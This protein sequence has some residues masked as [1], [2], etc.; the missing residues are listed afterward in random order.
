MQEKLQNYIESEAENVDMAKLEEERNNLKN[1][2]KAINTA[3]KVIESGNL[4]AFEK[5]KTPGEPVCKGMDSGE[6]ALYKKELQEMINNLQ[7]ACYNEK[8][9]RLR[10]V[11]KQ[12]KD[13]ITETKPI[14]ESLKDDKVAEGILAK[15][16]RA[17]KYAEI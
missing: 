7:K 9:S 17:V 6:M 8:I 15:V 1:I 16:E 14:I 2:E 12:T 13:Y 5:K 11:I 3:D 10:A 4:W